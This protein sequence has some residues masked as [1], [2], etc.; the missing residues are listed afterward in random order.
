[1]LCVNCGARTDCAKL[2]CLIR[3]ADSIAEQS[4]YAPHH[5]G[6][7]FLLHHLSLF[8]FM[9][10]RNNNQVSW[11]KCKRICVRRILRLKFLLSHYYLISTRNRARIYIFSR[12]GEGFLR[13]L[14]SRHFVKPMGTDFWLRTRLDGGWMLL[15]AHLLDEGFR[16]EIIFT[17][18]SSYRV[19]EIS[20]ST[21]QTLAFS[22]VLIRGVA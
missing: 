6:S 20:C 8:L 13:S 2:L 12:D 9:R 10:P 17:P 22:F 7:T 3:R 5:V 1:M 16:K 21:I 15:L 4:T 14:Y 18:S 19:A 11:L